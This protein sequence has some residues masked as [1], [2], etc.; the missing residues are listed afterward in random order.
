MSDQAFEARRVPEHP[1][2][3]VAA[4]GAAGGRHTVGIDV[5]ELGDVISYRH[6]VVVRLPAPI[7]ID[8]VRELLTVSDR[9]ARVRHYN[10]VARAGEDLGVPA[11]RPAFTPFAL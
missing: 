9:S 5:G 8:I 4:I 7:L 3:H 6:D 11:I 1:V 2:D 10:H